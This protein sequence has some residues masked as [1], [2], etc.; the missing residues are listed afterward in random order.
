MLLI[1]C[2]VVAT[3]LFS[4]GKL[5]NLDLNRIA[6]YQMIQATEVY[7]CIITISDNKINALNRYV[8][9]MGFLWLE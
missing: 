5:T 3:L 1:P 2:Q 4:I 8:K 6:N 7:L 9:F